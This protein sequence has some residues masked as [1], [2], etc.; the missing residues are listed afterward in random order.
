VKTRQTD[1]PLEE[2]SLNILAMN[3]R[4]VAN[5]VLQGYMIVDPPYQRT[6]VWNED[7]R[8]GLVESWCRGVPIPSLVVN[9][10]ASPSYRGAW[11]GPQQGNITYAVVDGR[12]RVE[13]AI[14]WYTS[15]LAVPASWFPRD[16]VETTEET[17]DGPYVRYSGLSKPQQRGV[18]FS[19][20]LPWAEARLLNIEE[21]ARL[22][23]LLN[24]AGTSQT[25]ADLERALK[26]AEGR[27][28]R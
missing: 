8:I 9:N 20:K 23:V 3:A 16:G 1:A 2:Y 10:R 27:S 24:S 6:S 18:A 22:Y 17:D 26:V 14:A 5:N 4:E 12:Q 7:Q 15:Q 19:F 28:G 13:T 21:E 11:Q 25:A